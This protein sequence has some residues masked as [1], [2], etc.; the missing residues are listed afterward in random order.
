MPRS[1]AKGTA[2]TGTAKP[3]VVTR[4]WTT[5]MVTSGTIMARTLGTGGL[6]IFSMT[7]R[8]V[9]S[10]HLAMGTNTHRGVRANGAGA[11]QGGEKLE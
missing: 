5:V 6:G 7:S 9:W 11:A 1:R 10:K 3:A 2:N 4:V 8:A